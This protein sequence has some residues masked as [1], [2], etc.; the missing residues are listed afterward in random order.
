[1]ADIQ[2]RIFGGNRPR[3]EGRQP[4]PLQRFVERVDRETNG[5]TPALQELVRDYQEAT[6]RRRG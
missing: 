4:T 3:P 6:A 5:P 1:M 2:F